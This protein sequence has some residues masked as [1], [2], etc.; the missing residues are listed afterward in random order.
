MSTKRVWKRAGTLMVSLVLLLSFIVTPS[1]TAQSPTP[2]M[3]DPRLDVRTVLTGL[4]TPTTMAFLSANE[5]LVLE[6]NTG[7]VQYVVDG[8]IHHTA[9][10]LAV[11]RASE[12]GLLG[13]ALDP[14]FENNH[15]VYLYWSCKA[16]PPTVDPFTPSQTE[17]A[18]T[19]EL[20]AD[21]GELLEVPLLGNRVD[22]FI[23]DG[24]NLSFDHNL[25]KLRSFQNDAGPVP[26]GQG[27][28]SQPPRGNHDGGVIAF[29]LDG[30]LYIFIGD[31]GR[32]GQMQNLPCGPTATCP[33]PIMPD[34]QFGGPEPDD[35]HLT[36]VVL[37]LNTDGSA[38]TDNP[39]Y[40]VGAAMGGE[41]GE[42][43]Q[44]IFSYGHR[45]SFGLA[46]DPISGAIWLQ[47]NGDDTFSELNRVEAGMNGGWIQIMGPAE[48]VAEYKAIETTF[49][50]MALQQLRWPPTNLADSPK[51][52]LKRLFMLPGARFTPPIL[53]WKWEVA[54]GGMGF[55][56]GE[57]LGTEFQNDL[58]MGAATPLLEGGYLFHFNF[59]D[60][61]RKLR[62][63]DPRLQDRVADNLAKHEI[64]ESESLLIGRDFG[65]ITDIETGPNGNLF[66]VSL[67]HGAVYEIFAVE[68]GRTFTTTLTGAAEAPDPGDPDG[69]GTATITLNPGQEEVCWEIQV[70]GITLPAS[71]AHIHEAP[72]GEPGPVVIGLSA[73]DASG[74]ASG[75][76]SADREQI[77]EI[78]QNP[79][80]YY[81][82]VHNSDFPAG[83]LRGQLS[84]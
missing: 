47:E 57:G 4:T 17:C 13:I 19:P 24:T 62:V 59:S 26:P 7:M 11:N 8:A 84:K 58:F 44:K 73:P 67:T 60:K 66:V 21:S 2:S 37:R 30:M 14:D 45:N 29:G 9:L 40:S 55:V 12:R 69:T 43:I 79:E 31:V 10:D 46:V 80:E 28:E 38:P 71:A 27:D 15:A 23:W 72:V 75:C 82:N 77:I 53:S 74:V 34:D 52:A 63:E 54:P 50:A 32:R 78:I 68:G 81:V 83:A 61:G 20:G 22:R 5:F 42:N 49:G 39:F 64:T 51:E 1:V 6:K 56:E 48:R 36:G 18:D 3:L 16:P 33:G 25:I 41:V 70:S 35:A 76:T 65:V